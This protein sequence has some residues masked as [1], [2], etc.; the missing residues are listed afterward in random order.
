MA[1]NFFTPQSTDLEKIC[2]N[3]LC[4]DPAPNETSGD[5]SKKG[6]NYEIKH[7]FMLKNLK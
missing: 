1:R 3:D 6:K 7:L 4:L 2:K 5:A